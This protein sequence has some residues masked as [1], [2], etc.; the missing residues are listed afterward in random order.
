MQ[1]RCSR[2]HPEPF[3]TQSVSAPNNDTDNYGKSYGVYALP[4]LP[5]I[6]P[7]PAASPPSFPASVTTTSLPSAFSS[8]LATLSEV[9]YALLIINILRLTIARQRHAAVQRLTKMTL[10]NC[11]LCLKILSLAPNWV[12]QTLIY[13]LIFYSM[14]VFFFFG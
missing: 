6:Y 2:F 3:E 11:Y 14:Y 8:L 10:M 9:P 4:S 12:V 13:C 1:W 5:D 7:S